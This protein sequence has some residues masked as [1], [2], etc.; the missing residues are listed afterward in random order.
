MSETPVQPWSDEEIA[1]L[2]E[3]HHQDKVWCWWDDETWPCPTIRLVAQ[4]A[5]ANADRARLERERDDYLRMLIRLTVTHR[6]AQDAFD[7]SCDRCTEIGDL[8]MGYGLK[9]PAPPPPTAHDGLPT[10]PGEGA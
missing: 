1:K 7:P 10:T 5:A 4:L 9:H 3:M 6:C 8:A 2:R